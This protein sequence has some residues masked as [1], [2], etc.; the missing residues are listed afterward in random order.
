MRRWGYARYIPP[1]TI[2]TRFSVLLDALACALRGYV[3]SPRKLSYIALRRKGIRVL[4]GETVG[5]MIP[6]L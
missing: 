5:R 1:G 2:Y 6:T 3:V 4:L